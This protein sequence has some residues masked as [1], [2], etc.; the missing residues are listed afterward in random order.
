[1]RLMCIVFCSAN[2]LRLNED[3]DLQLSIVGQCL[4]GPTVAQLAVF[5][6]F[7]CF[8]LRVIFFVPLQYMFMFI[9][10]IIFV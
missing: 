8:E 7:G 10:V 2:H 6:S 9:D 5:F 4:T 1:M 3:P